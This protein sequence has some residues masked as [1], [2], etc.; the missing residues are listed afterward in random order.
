MHLPF[1]D[2]NRALPAEF[3]V[4]LPINMFFQQIEEFNQRDVCKQ[5][6]WWF[7]AMHFIMTILITTTYYNY[8]GQSQLFHSHH[9]Y[10]HNGSRNH[11]SLH[12]VVRIRK[13]RMIPIFLPFLGPLEK[14]H[15]EGVEISAGGSR[16][17]SP[18]GPS[19]S[20]LAEIL[21]FLF[22]HFWCPPK[23]PGRWCHGFDPSSST[24]IKPQFF[25]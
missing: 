24:K 14:N 22:E 9:F 8:N 3:G 15:Q 20:R 19:L 11:H 25:F 12:S 23:S 4:S 1:N 6:G 13:A 18:H 17:K 21:G 5:C 16:S 2:S 7:H 10:C